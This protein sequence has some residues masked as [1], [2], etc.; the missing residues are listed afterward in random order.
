MKIKVFFI[1]LFF[2]IVLTSIVLPFNY[3]LN[4][5]SDDSFFYLQTAYNFSNGFGSTFDT[6]NKT[7]G[8]HP[9]WFLFLSGYFKI[10]NLFGDFSREVLFRLV[11]L[12]TG[13]I[14]FLSFNLLYHIYRKLSKEFA[15]KMFYLTFGFTFGI[16]FY[17]LIGLENNIL[18]LLFLFYLYNFISDEHR[19]H[20]KIFKEG[21]ILA[22]LFLAR[23]DL[24]LF[25]FLP[26]LISKVKECPKNWMKNFFM[27]SFP[28]IVVICFYLIINK[29]YFGCLLS[30]SSYYKFSNDVL[31]NLSF[32]T[33]PIKTPIEFGLLML[34]IIN[35]FIIFFG[36]RKYA[37][38]NL[39]YTKFLMLL[40]V[41]TLIFLFIHM[42]FNRQ[43]VREW[44]YTCPIFVSFL[45]ISFI[46]RQSK[47]Y[48]TIV[49]FVGLFN[50]FYFII[51]RTNYYDHSSAYLFAKKLDE[52]T[53]FDDVLF[54]VDYSGIVSFFSKR[55]IINGDGLINSCE[56][57]NIQKRRKVLEYLKKLNPDYLIFYS[58]DK[59]FIKDDVIYNFNLM[60][61]YQ[62]LF[63]IERVKYCST[64]IHGGIFR[65][66][67]GTFFLIDTK[68]FW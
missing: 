56:Y 10:L 20:V 39:R 51:F 18:L 32:L 27:L 62:V 37:I 6:I 65:K 59:V 11:F 50:I 53:K 3:P 16:S 66:K 12:L 67:L 13:V 17:F 29:L 9:L 44:Y 8:Y 54:Q 28:S 63:P 36:E 31:K 58:F 52:V 14:N 4:F 57:Y 60:Y 49:V 40:Y 35:F 46:L 34:L 7:N 48:K 22:L 2:F 25:I 42:I 26:I 15:E 38:F 61:N 23:I 55:K 33:N 24:W 68:N 19:N 1:L 21:L 47:F 64:L 45:V 41:S 5:T 43:G 30:I